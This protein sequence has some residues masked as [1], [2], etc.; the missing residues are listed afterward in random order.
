MATEP[1]YPQ[2]VGWLLAMADIDIPDKLLPAIRVAFFWLALPFIGVLLGSEKISNGSYYEAAAWFVV[3]LLGIVVAV[4][5]NRIVTWI[6]PR[7]SAKRS[8]RYLSDR[9]SDLG[10]AIITM[11]LRSA[12]ARWFSAQHLV[13][14]GSAID[15]THLIQMAGTIVMDKMLDG[16]L[17]VRGRRPGL[18]DYEVIPRT[19][20]Q[21]SR[22][23]FV[24]DPRSLWKMVIF[25]V[26]KTEFA[27]DG[28]IVRASDPAAA[29]RT[30]RLATYDSLLVDAYQ[31]ENLWP[32]KDVLADRERRKF[33]WRAWRRGLDKDEIRRLCVANYR[34]SRFWRWAHC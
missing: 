7:Y 9:D 25:P 34:R 4:R 28:A 19:H 30:T 24:S 20:W 8:L 11:A 18:L 1:R 6:W 16:D 14:N 22:L 15:Q 26:G 21:S 10:S 27:R 29:A 12:W 31:F 3:A 17:E 32:L 5:W 23:H 13:N 33:L 2:R